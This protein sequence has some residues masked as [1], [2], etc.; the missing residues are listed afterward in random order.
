MHTE[1]TEGFAPTG[2]QGSEVGG[3]T[4]PGGVVLL[5][6]APGLQLLVGG[7]GPFPPGLVEFPPQL[8]DPVGT[9]KRRERDS[10][11]IFHNSHSAEAF[12]QERLTVD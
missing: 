7:G 8:L 2:T 10:G 6:Q 4:H 11:F 12:Y 3:R 5:A 9:G 1:G